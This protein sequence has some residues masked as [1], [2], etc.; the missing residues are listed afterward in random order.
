MTYLVSQYLWMA[1]SL[2]FFLL[3]YVHLSTHLS[4]AKYLK[5]EKNKNGEIENTTTA[6]SSDTYSFKP[7]P[8]FTLRH[9]IA[10][11]YFGAIN[12][13][14]SGGY[15]II[16]KE[17]YLFVAT[18]VTIALFFLYLAILYWPP[19]PR[20]CM[21]LANSFFLAALIASFITH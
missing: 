21:W 5:R 7:W 19:L 15:F 2:V 8:G 10:A 20:F 12:L 9:S 14:L 4:G 1:A 16:V 13:I 6:L 18:A 17:S 11:I 3:G